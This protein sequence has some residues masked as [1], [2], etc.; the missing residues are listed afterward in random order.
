VDETASAFAA[1]KKLDYR[2]GQRLEWQAD[3]CSWGAS[4]RQS[5][6]MGAHNGHFSALLFSLQGWK[7]ARF[8]FFDQPV[9]TRTYF[10]GGVKCT[11]RLQRMS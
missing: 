11:F 3:T 6:V 4:R 7:G 10:F 5:M 1:D 2:K 8:S 9:S